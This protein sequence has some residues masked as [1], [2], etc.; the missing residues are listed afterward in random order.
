MSL[1]LPKQSNTL[2]MT[3]TLPQR[4]PLQYLFLICVP[5]RHVLEHVDHTPQWS[6]SLESETKWL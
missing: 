2:H 6:D 1:H 3:F 4:T 5:P